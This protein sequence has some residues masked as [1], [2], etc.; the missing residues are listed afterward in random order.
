MVATEQPVWSLRRGYSGTFDLLWLL[1]G[2]DMSRAAVLTDLKTH[3]PLEPRYPK[4]PAYKGPAYDIDRIQNQAYKEA[5]EEMF[6]AAID[7]TMVLI[8]TE[9]GKYVEDWEPAPENAWPL[10]RSLYHTMEG[11]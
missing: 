1:E 11:R 2:E 4:D 9:D 10:I 7:Y 6:G 3:A 5:H 8:V